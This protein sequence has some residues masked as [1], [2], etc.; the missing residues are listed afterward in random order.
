VKSLRNVKK[1]SHCVRWKKALHY[2][3]L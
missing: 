1:G 3:C 2:K